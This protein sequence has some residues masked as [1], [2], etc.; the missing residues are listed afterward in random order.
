MIFRGYRKN[1]TEHWM[2]EKAQVKRK[3]SKQKWEQKSRE[4]IRNDPKAHAAY[5]DYAKTFQKALR[6]KHPERH[7]LT[8]AKIRAK[9]KGLPFDIVLADIVIPK[10]C[11]IFGLKL[12]VADGLAADASPELDRIEPSK[13]YVRGNIMVI[14]RRANRIKNDASLAELQ[15]LATFY[16]NLK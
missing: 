15:Q 10:H 16:A 13:G 5:N 8:R 1:G 7:M 12:A 6:R 2:S 4:R 9:Q 14:S 11:P 3:A